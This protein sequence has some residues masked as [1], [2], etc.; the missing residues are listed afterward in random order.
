MMYTAN[1]SFA[2][3]VCMYK[4]EVRELSEAAASELLRCG[5]ISEVEPEPEKEEAHETKRGNSGKRKACDAH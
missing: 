2:G 3:K 1:V 4:G 5:Y